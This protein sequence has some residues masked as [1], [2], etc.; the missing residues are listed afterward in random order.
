MQIVYISTLSLAAAFFIYRRRVDLFSL[1]FA[2]I[3][4]VSPPYLVGFLHVPPLIVTPEI[5]NTESYLL[6]IFMLSS[7]ATF[8]F[9]FDQ[10]H[11]SKITQLN[12]QQNRA[13]FRKFSLLLFTLSAIFL[14]FAITYIGI[15]TISKIRAG[16]EISPLDSAIIS[17][18]ILFATY[19]VLFSFLSKSHIISIAG[20]S[21]LML[22]FFMLPSRSYIFIAIC[23]ILMIHFI[24]KG[25]ISFSL[26][27]RLFAYSIFII[28]F[29]ILSKIVRQ[30][31]ESM[32]DAAFNQLNTLLSGGVN[33]FREAN[34][35]AVN[36]QY[37]FKEL[38]PGE[39]MERH[40]YYPLM[41][42]PFLYISL[43]N[44]FDLPPITSFSNILADIHQFHDWGIGSSLWGE[45]YGAGGWV[46]IIF[47][48][49]LF[50]A[51]VYWINRVF[52]RGSAS[53][54][55]VAFLLP[56]VYIA[57]YSHRLDFS[58][59]MNRF[60]DAIIILILF[61]TY[62]AITNNFKVKRKALI[63]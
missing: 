16:A 31:S 34:Y 37:S 33:V 59:I 46:S 2:S 36:L 54:V 58:I 48:V 21:V 12:P 8:A 44:I 24:P 11:P 10:N 27:L 35:I 55:S 6:M 3:C 17:K 29:L 30:G 7:L 57:A 22:L 9:I 14:A 4:A 63:V 60:S 5:I 32:D 18:L 50:N 47:F 15:G 28:A 49:L 45:F 26:T 19:S 23:S 43:V 42:I 1:W 62:S 13:I 56:A 53:V 38:N 61:I 40:F 39:L 20:I 25:K 52:Y 51:F 41:L